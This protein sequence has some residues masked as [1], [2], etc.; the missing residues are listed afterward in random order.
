MLETGKTSSEVSE[1]EDTYQEDQSCYTSHLMQIDSSNVELL[2]FQKTILKESYS[3]T[4]S[5]LSPPKFLAEFDDKSYPKIQE[6]HY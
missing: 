2:Q 3:R 5:L 6:S 4:K 1:M